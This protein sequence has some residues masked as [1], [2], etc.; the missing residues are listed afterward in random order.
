MII[1]SEIG[2]F[3][4]RDED[5]DGTAWRKSRRETCLHTAPNHIVTPRTGGTCVNWKSLRVFLDGIPTRTLR[6]FR[7][8]C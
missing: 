4:R 1:N 8:T 2:Y 3:K 5:I 7:N 6:L